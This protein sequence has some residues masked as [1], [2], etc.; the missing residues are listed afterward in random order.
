M[1]IHTV[2][3]ALASQKDEV[4][5]RG[6]SLLGIERDGERASSGLHRCDVG[7]VRVN[8]ERGLVVPTQGVRPSSWVGRTSSSHCFRV[9][10]RLGGCIGGVRRR[11]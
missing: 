5:D 3:E 10:G 6:W 1:E 2:V 9:C 4:V 11:G 8:G 7:L